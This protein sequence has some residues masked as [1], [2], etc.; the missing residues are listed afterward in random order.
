M[1]RSGRLLVPV[2]TMDRSGRL[3][4]LLLLPERSIVVPLCCYPFDNN[5]LSFIK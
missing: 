2:D 3:F 5:G 4:L 1:G